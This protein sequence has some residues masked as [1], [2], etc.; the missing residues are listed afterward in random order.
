MPV[1]KIDVLL[2]AAFVVTWSS[3]FIAAELGTRSASAATL[4]AWRFLI[5]AAVL[6]AIMA[7]RR[8]RVRARD[9][10]LHAL[11]GL[12]A[13]GGYLYGVF[14]A[15]QH[16]VSA[17][18]N[19]L[20]TAL[21]PI[22]AVV[23]AV[24]VLGQRITGRQAAGFAA[25]LAGVAL[26][27]GGDLKG[28]APAWAY[29]LPAAAMLCLVGATLI[30]RR[31]RPSAGIPE[32]LAVQAG[33]SMLLF[34]GIAGVT[35]DLTPPSDPGFWIAVAMVVVMAM[36]GG[37]GLY[38][39]NVR[40]T[41]VTRVSAL[42]YLTPPTTMLWGWAAFGNTLTPLSLAGVLV[43]GGAVLLI[44]RRP[45]DQARSRS[46]RGVG[47]KPADSSAA[48]SGESPIDAPSARSTVSLPRTPSRTASA[49]ASTAGC[50]TSG[51][52]SQ[53]SSVRPPRST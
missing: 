23:L 29:A 13:Q 53:V 46:P 45:A 12:L 26:V 11:I 9:L 4:L 24:P 18:V 35:G 14:L 15:T 31:T 48:A 52:S 1:P 6:A 19:D 2:G 20:I 50:R 42:L 37:Y 44:L 36:F 41:G 51:S 5:A 34:T 33:I 16:G 39:V 30:E 28:G 38:W 43:C 8:R 21:Q 47:W 17:G 40:R 3:G 32:A 49:S 10:G 27:V 22:A 25:G 7:R